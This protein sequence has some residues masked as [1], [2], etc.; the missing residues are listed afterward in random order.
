MKM[1]RKLILPAIAIAILGFFF[2]VHWDGDLHP[3]GDYVR[4]DTRGIAHP[5]GWPLIQVSPDSQKVRIIWGKKIPGTLTYLP[6]KTVVVEFDLADGRYK[7]LE[8]NGSDL[9]N[10]RTFSAQ[11]YLKGGQGISKHYLGF[12]FPTWCLGGINLGDSAFS[13]GAGK[14]GLAQLRFEDGSQS[15]VVAW[16]IVLGD[17]TESRNTVDGV[18][19]DSDHE[20]AVIPSEDRNRFYIAKIGNGR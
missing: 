13:I 16:K 17:A 7:T 14:N 18:L 10:W 8:F 5:N 9:Q 3:S 12:K 4:L 15:R 1:K 6:D 19:V 20:F 2:V 11:P